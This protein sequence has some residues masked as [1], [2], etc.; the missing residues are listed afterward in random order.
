MTHKLQD[1]VIH[2]LAK[3]RKRAPLRLLYRV[4]SKLIRGCENCSYDSRLNGEEVLLRKLRESGLRTF[5][6]VGANRGDW[7]LMVRHFFPGSS[8]HCF[9][10]APAM[11]EVLESALKPLQPPATLNRFGLS[12]HNGAVTVNFCAENDGLSTM[13]DPSIEGHFVEVKATVETGDSYVKR[14]A[15]SQIDFLKLDV[16]GAESFVLNGFFDTLKS[17]AI[18]IIQ[19]EYGKASIISGFLL[20]DFYQLLEPL[21]YAIGKLYPDGV[22]FMQYSTDLEN[23]I[24]PNFVAVP[25]SAKELIEHLS[26]GG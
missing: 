11:Y 3:N 12:D 17:Q 15:I 9:E 25:A 13:L 7:S 8:I 18:R 6:D 21:G 14:N 1:R 23:F 24:G 10:I 22:D 5:F 26:A 4:A 2:H 20:K 19:F 16:E